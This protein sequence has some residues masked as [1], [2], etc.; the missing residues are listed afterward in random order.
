MVLELLRRG[1]VA[2]QQ[3]LVDRL[4]ELGVAATQTTLSRDLAAIGAVKSPLGY[5]L[6]GPALAGVAGAADT[7]DVVVSAEIGG[8]ILVLRTPPAHAH[9][10]AQRIDAM[11]DPDVLG[12]I[13]GDDT[14]FVA[15][16][17]VAAARRLATALF[18]PAALQ[19]GA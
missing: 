15:A 9:P 10:V 2:T 6:P 5:A 14:V 8:T 19:R 18:P 12:T 3:D 1:P 4:A 13:A 7:T 11:R 16:R 17:T